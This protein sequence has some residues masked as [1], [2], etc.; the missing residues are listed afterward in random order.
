MGRKNKSLVYQ[1]SKRYNGM[2]A[3]GE[4]KKAARAAGTAHQK[5]F[6]FPIGV[7]KLQFSGVFEIR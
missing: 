6:S 7:C 5:I 1:V 2:L 4:S 3:I